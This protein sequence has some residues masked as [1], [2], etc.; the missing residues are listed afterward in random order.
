MSKISDEEKNGVGVKPLEWEEG[1]GRTATVCV[2]GT[3]E[4]KSRPSDGAVD[5]Q[6]ANGAFRVW[7]TWASDLINGKAAAQADYERRILSAL[8]NTDLSLRAENERLR[9]DNSDLLAAADA[10]AY[11]MRQLLVRATTA[12]AK[13]EEA[14]KVLE[15][16][17]ALY[18]EGMRDFPDGTS[19]AERP[20]DR[21]AWGFNNVDLKWGDFRAAK[22][23]LANLKGAE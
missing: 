19:K 10:D 22:S 4:I 8:T 7:N 9:H 3:Y 17:V 6:L 12:E 14:A 15:P 18:D 11:V 23:F 2:V 5:V 20:D 13:L 21:H 16:F 1:W